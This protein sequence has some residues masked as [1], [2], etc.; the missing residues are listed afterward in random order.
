MGDI[1]LMIMLDDASQSRIEE[2]AKS[3][4]RSGVQVQ[5]KLPHLGTIIGLGDSSKIKEVQG[6]A[7]VEFV[8]PEATFQLPPMDEAIPQ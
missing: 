7:G 1:G 8:R 5:Q 2:V 3:V 4:E 6:I